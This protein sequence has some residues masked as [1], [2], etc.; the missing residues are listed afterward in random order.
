MA[1]S[2]MVIDIYDILQSISI[3]ANE[4]QSNEPMRTSSYRSAGTKQSSQ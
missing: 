4:W 3:I 2:S 1:W